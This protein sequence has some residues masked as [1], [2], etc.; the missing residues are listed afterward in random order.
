MTPLNREYRFPRFAVVIF[1]Q[2]PPTNFQVSP[3]TPLGNKT[4]F[5]IPP[6]RTPK[7]SIGSYAIGAK[8]RGE[9]PMVDVILVQTPALYSHVSPS[10][11]PTLYL[12]PPKRTT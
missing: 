1:V 5:E 3:R 4:R 11:R 9:G 2:D 7:P 10:P 12:V 8:R 6:N